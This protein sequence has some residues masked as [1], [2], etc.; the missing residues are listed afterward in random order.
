M[1]RLAL[2]PAAVLAL[3][4]LTACSRDTDVTRMQTAW[5][6]AFASSKGDLDARKAAADAG[7][8]HA[9]THADG[10]EG[11]DRSGAARAVMILFGTAV[12]AIPEVCKRHGV[13][14]PN[15]PRVF[16]GR[17]SDAVAAAMLQLDGAAYLDDREKEL[18]DF[19]RTQLESIGRAQGKS[20]ADTCKSLDAE[21]ARGAKAEFAKT[22]GTAFSVLD[23]K[24]D[25]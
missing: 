5:S 3:L 1:T 25:W 17:T 14:V 19:A 8:E 18:D 4:C 9:L 12:G 7:L 6:D 20:I 11:M 24:P 13:D 23:V 10:R 2:T 16:A 21:S 15:Y 22:L